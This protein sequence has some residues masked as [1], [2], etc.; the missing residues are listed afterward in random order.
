[1]FL[2]TEAVHIYMALNFTFAY[3]PMLIGVVSSGH[4]S[5]KLLLLIV[6]KIIQ[7]L[8]HA[9]GCLYPTLANL[10]HILVVICT[11]VFILADIYVLKAVHG[12]LD[13][14]LQCP[15]P[16]QYI[17]RTCYCS[18]GKDLFYDSPTLFVRSF[19]RATACKSVSDLKEAPNKLVV[20]GKE[21]TYYHC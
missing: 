19:M 21:Y 12:S 3:M 2:W 10:L 5:E 13:C 6:S 9:Y 1:M 7:F 14:F 11:F 17:D 15:G 18:I 4:M 20:H 16:T 8:V